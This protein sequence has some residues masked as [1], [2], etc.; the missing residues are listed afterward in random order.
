M[1]PPSASSENRNFNSDPPPAMD[2][3]SSTNNP[4]NEFRKEIPI[5]TSDADMIRENNL[6]VGQ[7]NAESEKRN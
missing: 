2:Q 6:F 7:R 4:D 3:P 1:E 5:L